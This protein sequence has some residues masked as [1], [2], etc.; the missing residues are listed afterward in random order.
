VG[1]AG[2]GEAGRGGVWRREEGRERAGSGGGGG[3]A[4][5]M[6]AGG[7][8]E[9]AAPIVEAVLETGE[10]SA[11]LV[12]ADEMAVRQ[13]RRMSVRHY[14]K[15]PARENGNAIGTRRA[16]LWQHHCQL[17]GLPRRKRARC[18]RS[19]MDPAGERREWLGSLPRPGMHGGR[20]SVLKASPCTRW[21]LRVEGCTM[22]RLMLQQWGQVGWSPAR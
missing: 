9:G 4:V 5:P 7:S 3:S 22:R 12:G 2:H 1:Y 20:R 6:L 16:V 10:V 17:A 8:G 15:M 13:V 19:D 14:V 11:Y 18:P 21:L